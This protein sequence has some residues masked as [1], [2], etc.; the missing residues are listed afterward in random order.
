MAETMSRKEVTLPN[1]DVIACEEKAN[2][3]LMI[4]II[5][6]HPSCDMT[7]AEFDHMVREF[8]VV[9]QSASVQS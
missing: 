2:K 6:T 1:G 7:I 8:M 5:G 9:R 4:E 3:G